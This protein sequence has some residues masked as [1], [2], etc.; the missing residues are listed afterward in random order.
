MLPIPISYPTGL[1]VP[2]QGACVYQIWEDNNKE[3]EE[4]IQLKPQK[5]YFVIPERV[6]G[7]IC[8]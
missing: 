8:I 2:F 3:F 5:R 4:R 6:A 7:W 1:T